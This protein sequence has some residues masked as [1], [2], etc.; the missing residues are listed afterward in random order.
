MFTFHGRYAFVRIRL[1][2]GGTPYFPAVMNINIDP[3]T[4]GLEKKY[5]KRGADTRQVIPMNALRFL[6][7]VDLYSFLLFRYLNSSKIR[8]VAPS[9]AAVGFIVKAKPNA[10]ALTYRYFLLDSFTNMK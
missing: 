5:I 4:P 2:S 10:I 8:I 3:E 9:A 1:T 6:R 7:K